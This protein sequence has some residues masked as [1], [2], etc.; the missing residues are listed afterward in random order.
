MLTSQ[1]FRDTFHFL[2]PLSLK[3]AGALLKDSPYSFSLSGYATAHNPPWSACTTT[4]Y[5]DGGLS[6]NCHVAFSLLDTQTSPFR[7][8]A[9]LIPPGY[10]ISGILSGRRC[11]FSGCITSWILSVDILPYPD[12]SHPE[13]C[14]AEVPTS[15]GISQPPFCLAEVSTSPDVS[16]PPFYLAKVP[17]FPDVSQP[18]FCSTDVPPSPDVSHPAPVR[19]RRSA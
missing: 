5:P 7:R 19:R 15:P 2:S 9:S 3:A 12:I 17:T 13:S 18:P 10:L 11:I 1:A 16:Q 14:P 6:K 8:V 4:Y